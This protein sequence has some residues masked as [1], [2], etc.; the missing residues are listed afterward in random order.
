MTPIRGRRGQWLG[1]L[2]LTALTGLAVATRPARADEADPAV[3]R[4]LRDAPPR[5]EEYAGRVKAVQ[6]SYTLRLSQTLAGATAETHIT[7][8]RNGD[9]HRLLHAWAENSSEGK[10]VSPTYEVVGVNPRYAF[11]LNRKSTDSPWVA[12]QLIDLT[13]NPVPP[14]FDSGFNNF[15]FDVGGLVQLYNQP[16]AAVVQSPQFRVRGCRDI[17][18]DGEDLV[19]VVFDYPHEVHQQTDNK[20]QGGTLVLD[21]KRYW[22]VRSFDVRT[23]TPGSTGTMRLR[24]LELGQT[25][26]SLPVPRRM[27][28]E[29]HFV[30][31]DGRTNHQEFQFDYDLD[32]PRKPP[33]EEEFI[34][35][36]FGLAEP[37][38]L[39]GPK[40]LMPL[41]VWVALAGLGCLALGVFFQ[42]LKRRAARIAPS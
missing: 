18:E 31:D 26:G 13:H 9:R 33:A 15:E 11:M 21:P 32:I 10:K 36:A 25:D 30:F 35:S 17:V 42:M 14:E 2:S 34:V 6:G 12:T 29:N 24:V 37:P 7:V 5:W 4:F 40:R 3:A 1:L 22:C 41:Y 8:K 23:K 39:G 20:V 27:V 28:S 38:G 19:E 16:L